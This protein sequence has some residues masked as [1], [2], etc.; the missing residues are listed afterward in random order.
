MIKNRLMYS[1]ITHCLNSLMINQQIRIYREE[2]Q[3][4][5]SFIKVDLKLSAVK[6]IIEQKG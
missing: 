2:L 1:Q 4:L 5:K 3:L 6:E